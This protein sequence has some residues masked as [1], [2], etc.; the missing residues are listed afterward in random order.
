M[1]QLTLKFIQKLDNLPQEVQFYCSSEVSEL[2]LDEFL[3]RNKIDREILI[4]IFYEVFINDF[5]LDKIENV[6]SVIRYEL[7]VYRNIQ[8]LKK[9]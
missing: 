4:N 2:M 7:P 9:K 6:F 3:G 8:G 5:D 1:A